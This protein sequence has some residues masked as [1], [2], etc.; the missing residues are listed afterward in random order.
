MILSNE[1]MCTFMAIQIIANSIF[2]AHHEQEKGNKH[3]LLYAFCCLS[4][5]LIAFIIS[6]SL[7]NFSWIDIYYT[8][9]TD[10]ESKGIISLNYLNSGF[11]ISKAHTFYYIASS[12]TK[13]RNL[14]L[15]THLMLSD[16]LMTKHF[17]PDEQQSLLLEELQQCCLIPH[18]LLERVRIPQ[19]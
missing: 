3:F 5:M 18:G 9:F 6:F 19:D 14:Y 15:Y 7:S 2:S 11:Y 1:N 16:L 10:E 13:R 12:A 17:Y 4:N 8:Y